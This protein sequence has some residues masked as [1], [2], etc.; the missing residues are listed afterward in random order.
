MDYGKLQYQQSKNERKQKA[1]SKK[2]ELKMVRFSLRTGA[3]D[4]DFKTKQAVKFLKQGH[5]LQIEIILRG[6]EKA[7]FNLALRKIEDFIKKLNQEIQSEKKKINQEQ[8]VRRSGRGLNTLI[9]LK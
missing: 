9:C 5:K 1:K 6:R 4:L 2:T 8:P 7:L 3:H